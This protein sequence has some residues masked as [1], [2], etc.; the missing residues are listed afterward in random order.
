MDKLVKYEQNRMVRNIQNFVFWFFFLNKLRPFWKTF[1]WRNVFNCG[2]IVPFPL[3]YIDCFIAN[4]FFE[5]RRTEKENFDSPFYSLH[6]QIVLCCYESPLMVSN[7]TTG[8][9]VRRK[10]G[11]LGFGPIIFSY[12]HLVYLVLKSRLRTSMSSW[13]NNNLPFSVNGAIIFFLH[14]SQERNRKNST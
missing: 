5:K 13:I 9:S 8:N 10:N 3:K 6:L 14:W 4:T 1:L 2:S 11:C 7:S 12:I